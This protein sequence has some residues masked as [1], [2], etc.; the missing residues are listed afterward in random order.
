[1]KRPTRY[2]IEY[3]DPAF[4]DE[5]VRGAHDAGVPESVVKLEDI[6]AG[7][8]STLRHARAVAARRAKDHD[9]HVGI[10]ER[11]NVEQIEPYGPWTY[12]TEWREDA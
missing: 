2:F 8:L 12:E 7:E 1:M 5:E 4:T 10:Y 6:G 9:T 3:T 11:T